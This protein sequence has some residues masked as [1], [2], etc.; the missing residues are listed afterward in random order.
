MSV[1]LP[2]TPAAGQARR[3]ADAERLQL[4]S[5][6]FHALNQPITALRCSVELNLLQPRTAEQYCLALQNASE[7]GERIAQ[8][9]NGISALLQTDDPGDEREAISLDACL[10]ET[11]ADLQ[12]VAEAAD[13]KL[14]VERLTPCRVFLEPRRLR[15]ALFHLFEF[16]LTSRPAGGVVTLI[17]EESRTDAVVVLTAAGGEYLCNEELSPAEAGAREQELNRRLSFAIA[18]GIFERAGGSL[19]ELRDRPCTRIKLRLPLAA[20][21]M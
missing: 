20:R 7:H 15:Q 14:T 12:P 21:Q 17:A 4:I 11:V 8:L 6:L 9:S 2:Q 3:P 16:V 13:L 19:H 1:L 5:D 10:R 18:R